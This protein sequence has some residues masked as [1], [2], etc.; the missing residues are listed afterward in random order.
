MN[1]VHDGSTM[2]GIRI[3]ARPGVKVAKTPAG[4]YATKYGSSEDLAKLDSLV[5][6]VSLEN[7]IRYGNK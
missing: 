4:I 3:K 1:N 5:A 2:K 7:Q 6:K